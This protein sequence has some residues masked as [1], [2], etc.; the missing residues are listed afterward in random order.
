MTADRLEQARRLLA[1]AGTDAP[2]RAA[3]VEGDIVAVA[4]SPELRQPLAR[5]APSLRELGFRYVA[6]D[7][8]NGRRTSIQDS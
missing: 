8:G 2:V 4:G 5:L 7:L 3:G 6:L 1:E